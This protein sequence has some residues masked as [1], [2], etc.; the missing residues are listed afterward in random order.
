V[1][2]VVYSVGY[3][4]PPHFRGKALAQIT[5]RGLC[6]LT[7]APAR[8]NP[9]LPP[10]PCLSLIPVPRL[11]LQSCYDIMPLA[12]F[13]QSLNQLSHS[14]LQDV[15]PGKYWLGCA[16]SL[17][18]RPDLGLSLPAS[19]SGSGETSCLVSSEVMCCHSPTCW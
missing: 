6:Q 15:Q 4:F 16:R 5:H 1:E 18:P 10:S 12:F 9:I 7:S 17:R 3:G 2:Y 8:K 14:V 11:H 19:R 13:T